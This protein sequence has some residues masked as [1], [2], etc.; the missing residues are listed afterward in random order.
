M[1][2]PTVEQAANRAAF[3]LGDMAQKRYNS[4]VLQVAVGAAWEELTAQMLLAGVS[5]IELQA[6]YTLPADTDTLTPETA[7][8]SNFGEIIRLWERPAGSTFF[9]YPVKY[10]EV[11]PQTQSQT[12]RLYW[13]RW[14]GGHFAFNP[15]S[16]AVELKIEYYG[17]GKAPDSGS[18]GIDGCLQIVSKLAAAIAAPTLGENQLAATLRNEV[19]GDNDPK[20]PKHM[21]TF[22][23]PML[24]T[25]QRRGYKNQ[26][27]GTGTGR[28]FGRYPQILA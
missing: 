12:G 8:I 17:S 2:I 28:G 13:F 16:S 9:F 15:A 4:A 23:Q 27:Y 11:L 24:R 19:Y 10:I 7:G 26:A 25:Q 6:L 22:L 21:H 20:S 1:P 18:L 14:T 3:H 5:G